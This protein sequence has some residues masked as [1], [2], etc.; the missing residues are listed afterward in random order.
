[1]KNLIVLIFLLFSV[2]TFPLDVQVSNPR[3]SYNLSV[4][5]GKVKNASV[6]HGFFESVDLTTDVKT[7]WHGPGI[8]V[9]PPSAI[10]MTVSSSDALD[11]LA[12]TGAQK[13]SI[14]CLDINWNPFSE[15]VELDGQNPV[16]MSGACFRVQGIGS[17]VIQVGS[18][19]ANAGNVYIGTGT[20]TL[21]IPATIYNLIAIGENGSDSGFFSIPAGFKGYFYDVQ[22]SSIANKPLKL[23]GIFKNGTPVWKKFWQHNVSEYVD[24]KNVF[25]DHFDEKTDLQFRAAMDSGTGEVSAHAHMLLIR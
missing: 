23:T 15:T 19:Q 1:M 22:A 25:P 10:Q 18:L 4:V 7:V 11:A 13:I 3:M 12:G 14:D 21:G 5:Q 24:G 20:V 9:Y 8:Y 16:T 6:A 17:D 2:K